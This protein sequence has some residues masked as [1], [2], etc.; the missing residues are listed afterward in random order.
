MHSQPNNNMPANNA[1]DSAFD[2]YEK[3]L[4]ALEKLRTDYP[5]LE[6]YL[7]SLTQPVLRI[8]EVLDEL[9]DETV[10]IDV[11]SAPDYPYDTGNPIEQTDTDVEAIELEEIALNRPVYPTIEE[12]T[13]SFDNIEQDDDKPDSLEQLDYRTEL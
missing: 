4:K 10:A 9:A 7:D 3:L 6:P 5:T 12:L 13:P 2:A 11:D 1:T 8:G